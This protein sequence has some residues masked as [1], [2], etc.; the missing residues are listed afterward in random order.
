MNENGFYI[1][2]GKMIK[3]DLKKVLGAVKKGIL[4]QPGLVLKIHRL[5]KTQKIKTL[6]K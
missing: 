4:T 6:T 1:K 3:E 5:P 2:G